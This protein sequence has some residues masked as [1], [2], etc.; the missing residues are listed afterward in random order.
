MKKTLGAFFLGVAMISIAAPALARDDDDLSEL[1]GTRRYSDWELIKSDSI[2]N[3]KTYAKQEDGK[4][5]RSF[6]IEAQFDASL[7]TL[8]RVHFDVDNY[9]K[10]FYETRESRLLKKVSN[11][12][13][14]YYCR[15]AAPATLPDRDVILHAV[16]EPYT[17]RRGYMGLR[18]SAVP[19][20]LPETPGLVRMPAQE[21]YIKFTPQ[22]PD[23]TLLEV[24]GYVDPGGAAPVW[25]IN[26]VQRRAPYSSMVGLNRMVQ[27]PLYR[28]ANGPVPYTFTIGSYANE[29]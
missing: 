10:W 14:Y 2:R 1:R 22:G 11:T 27:S 16:V 24:E 17:A 18:V 9:K 13:F 3:I 15:Y 21:E 28:D 8:A 25:A 4:R 23:K 19:D 7:E 29:R 5:I 12:E 26:F 6:K 20:Y